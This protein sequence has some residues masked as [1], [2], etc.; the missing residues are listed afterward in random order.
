MGVFYSAVRPHKPRSPNQVF[1]F[2]LQDHPEYSRRL[3]ARLSEAVI[4]PPARV[5]LG[6]WLPAE[7]DCHANVATW[8]RNTQ[9]FQIVRGWLYFDMA[10]LM[11]IVLFNAHSVVRNER[12]ELWDITPT[13]ATSPYPFLIAE[14][15]EEEYA[16]FIEA[17][18][19][20]LR[21]FN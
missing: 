17:G 19:V 20:R 4:V 12:G 21:H 13:K 6:A 10:N 16:K 15:S 5:S 3:I 18:A 8:C 14:E 11:P 1:N 9:G 2:P 7:N